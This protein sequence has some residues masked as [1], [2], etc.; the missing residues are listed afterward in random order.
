MTIYIHALLIYVCSLCWH[1]SQQTQSRTRRAQTCK[2]LTGAG[3]GVQAS[4]PALGLSP[5]CWV[6]GGHRRT[7]QALFVIV[8]RASKTVSRHTCHQAWRQD[9]QTNMGERDNQQVVSHLPSTRTHPHRQNW[10]QICP[11]CDWIYCVSQPQVSLLLPDGYS[12]STDAQSCL[13]KAS[14]N[15]NQCP[16]HIS[17]VWGFFFWD[18]AISPG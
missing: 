5:E 11:G 12:N 17:Y 6:T 18:R 9:T 10:V 2:I 3:L 14:M 13:R 15:N 4:H 1:S 16:L 8:P 7:Q